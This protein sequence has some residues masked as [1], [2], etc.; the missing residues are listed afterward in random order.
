VH[1]DHNFKGLLNRL[2]VNEAKRIM[3]E[4]LRAREAINLPEVYLSSGFNSKSSF[5]RTFKN[6]TG[7]PPG[8]YI[9]QLEREMNAYHK[10]A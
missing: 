3:Q 9:E 1:G 4:C 2:R 10:P 5:Y 6:I 8:D 7:L